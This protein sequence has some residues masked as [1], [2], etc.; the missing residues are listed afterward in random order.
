MLTKRHERLA[1]LAPRLPWPRNVW[2]GVTIE[3]RRFV[4]RADSLRKVPAAVRFISAEPLLG[5]LEGLDL[6]GIDWLI[7][8][9][10]SGPQSSPHRP[11]MGYRTAR[12]L[13][14]RGTSPSSSSSGGVSAP[15]AAGGSSLAGIG[16]TCP[17]QSG[18]GLLSLSRE[19]HRRALGVVALSAPRR[20]DY[21]DFAGVLKW[22]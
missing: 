2:M 3:N 6:D 13:S 18:A 12:P 11:C 17:S 19:P 14:S 22:A 1:E 10:E 9:G 15:R 5:P 21:L 7:A 16:T 8:G 4:H 20:L